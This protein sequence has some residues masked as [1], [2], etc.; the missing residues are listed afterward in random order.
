[1]LFQ[2]SG[3]LRMTGSGRGFIRALATGRFPREELE[4]FVGG[5]NSLVDHFVA[6]P[7]LTLEMADWDGTTRDELPLGRLDADVSEPDDAVG[8]MIDERQVR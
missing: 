8:A 1:M 5:Q 3:L 4:R 7:A 6:D 2:Q